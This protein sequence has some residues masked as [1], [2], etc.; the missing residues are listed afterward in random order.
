MG[1]LNLIMK[2]LL[3][4]LLCSFGTPG[5]SVAQEVPICTHQ[6]FDADGDGFGDPDASPIIDCSAPLGFVS[7]ADDCN[8]SAPGINPGAP[9]LADN[10][11]DEDCDGIAQ[12]SDGDQDGDGLADS[13]ESTTGCDV[14][15][16]S[17]LSDP[18][19]DGDGV[20]DGAEASE[21]ARCSDGNIDELPDPS[22][23]NY[24]CSTT[25]QLPGWAVL[26]MGFGW[27]RRRTEVS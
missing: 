15:G 5:S 23:P 26:L 21:A 22:S 20:L 19:S 6:Y 9:E 1:A 16:R 17:S 3:V 2:S 13:E 4:A 14:D 25:T 8:D 24:G 11:I 27:R 7:N 10:A 18:D 12:T